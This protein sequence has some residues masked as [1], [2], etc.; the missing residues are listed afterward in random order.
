M[1]N[2]E[3]VRETP[4]ALARPATAGVVVYATAAGLAS[5]V[6]V[7]FIDA[8][9]SGYARG[10]AMRRVA[11]RRHVRLERG[12]R[13]VLSAPGLTRAEG[14]G[15]ARLLRAAVSRALAPIRVAT[16]VEEA[17]ATFFAAVLLDHYLLTGARRDGAP[18]EEAEARRVRESMEE[19]YAAVG[20]DALRTVPLGALDVVVRAAKATVAI[21]AEDRGPIERFVDA[22]LDGV[23]D[24]PEDFFQRLRE[25]FDDADRRRRVAR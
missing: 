2:A 6:P 12:A 21:D 23:A 3:L 24:A 17:L 4:R 18:I 11:A 1:V 13:R 19:A 16:R 5:M 15:A 9:L 20:L 7:P 25:A 14:T 8:V 22:L 10:A